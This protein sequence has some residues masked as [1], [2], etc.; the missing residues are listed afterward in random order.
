MVNTKPVL[1]YWKIRGLAQSIRYLLVY[2]EVDYENKFYETGDAPDYNTDSWFGIKY[3]L[4]FDFP[5]L[6]YFI[7][8]DFKLSE[9][10]ALMKYICAKWRPELLGT[11][12][13]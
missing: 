11:G 2:L 9:S 4:G 10:D 5:N 6:P 13:E 12:P 7:D 3:D 1:G 8:G